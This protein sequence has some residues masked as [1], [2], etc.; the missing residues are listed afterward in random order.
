[1]DTLGIDIGTL[2]VKYLRMKGR[3]EKGVVLSEGEYLYSGDLGDM[4]SILNAIRDKEGTDH[5]VAIAITSQ[6]ILK[7]TFTIPILPKDEI[8]EAVDWSASKVIGVPLE[9]MIYEHVVLGQITEKG[10]KKEE[11][12]FVGVS[13]D[14][15]N[16]LLSIFENAGFRRISAI[17]DPAFLYILISQEKREEAFAFVDIGGKQTGIYIFADRKLRFVREILTATESF[18]DVLM[19]ELNIPFHEAAE[20][21]MDKGLSQDVADILALPLDRLTGEIQRTF[22]VYDQ[23]WPGKPITKIFVS[24]RATK[25]PRFMEKFGEPFAEEVDCVTPPP[26][27][28]E[29]YLPAYTLCADKDPLVNLLPEKLKARRQEM[30]YKGWARVASMCV[31]ALLLIL[32]MGMVS[33]FVKAHLALKTEQVI[34]SSKSEQ[35]R[36][37]GGM[38]VPARYGENGRRRGELGKRD[39][40][41]IVILKYLSSHTPQNVYLKG[42][43]YVDKNRKPDTASGDPGKQPIPKGATVAQGTGGEG[44]N[45]SPEY[46]VTMR[47]VIFGEVSSLEPTLIDYMIK[48][49][50]SPLLSDVIISRKGPGDPK[51]GNGLEF[52]ITA[53]CLTYES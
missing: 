10:L 49:E 39:S 19:N 26:G 20:R 45:S 53:R 36:I 25:A 33:D 13:R 23:K 5:E 47:G 15:I 46:A 37:L 41:F 24:G 12:L 28:D 29:M 32:S 30:T 21:F 8:R 17:T 40:T 16:V 2:S 14:Y 4:Q 35:L 44:K 43:E 3:R 52:E 6:D 22:S 18:V 34:L 9:D 38:Q 27:I 50:A 7:R 42:I 31:A 48:L 51:S 11:V 1:M